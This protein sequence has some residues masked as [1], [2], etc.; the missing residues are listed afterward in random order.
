MF[1]MNEFRR[2][3]AEGHSLQYAYLAAHIREAW[4]DAEEEGLV[5]LHAVPDEVYDDSYVDTWGLS[6]ARAE[7]AKRALWDTI[8][9][10]G[11]WV[12]FAQVNQD[13]TWETVD[14][15]GGV[16]GD[17]TASGYDVDLKYAALSAYIVREALKVSP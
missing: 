9:R 4:E 13:G 12:Y 16:I 2:L 8:D 3:R 6:P 14:S 15:I 17:I 10:D 5:R 7:R 11:V 1:D